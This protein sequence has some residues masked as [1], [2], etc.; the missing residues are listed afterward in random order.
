M[1]GGVSKS[2]NTGSSPLAFDQTVLL[3]PVGRVVGDVPV[4]EV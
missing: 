4:T 3:K 2:N 1:V